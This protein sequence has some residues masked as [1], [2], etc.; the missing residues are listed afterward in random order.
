MNR[1]KKNE[2]LY[3]SDVE[4]YFCHRPKLAQSVRHKKRAYANVA[5]PK[6]GKGDRLRWMRMLRNDIESPPNV[7]PTDENVRSLRE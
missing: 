3:S 2:I 1:K 5:F 4:G 7:A 6:E